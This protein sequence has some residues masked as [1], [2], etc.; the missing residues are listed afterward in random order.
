MFEEAASYQLENQEDSIRYEYQIIDM[1]NFK[2]RSEYGGQHLLQAFC[3]Q[4]YSFRI[5]RRKI[6]PKHKNPDSSNFQYQTIIKLVLGN[7]DLTKTICE[8]WS[9][10]HGGRNFLDIIG[11]D[12]DDYSFLDPFTL[13]FE[14]NDK[15]NENLK[16]MFGFTINLSSVMFSNF[17]RQHLKHPMMHLILTTYLIESEKKFL[18]EKYSCNIINFFRG[19]KVASIMANQI[20]SD[21]I[22]QLYIFSEDFTDSWIVKTK[23]TIDNLTEY[24]LPEFDSDYEMNGTFFYSS[25]SNSISSPELI[26]AG[27]GFPF[28]LYIRC[29]KIQNEEIFSVTVSLDYVESASNKFYKL[30]SINELLKRS[31]KTINERLLHICTEGVNFS[32]DILDYWQTSDDR[33]RVFL[34]WIPNKAGNRILFN[35]KI[36]YQEIIDLCKNYQ[37]SFNYPLYEKPSTKIEDNGPI[38]ITLSVHFQSLRWQ[39]FQEYHQIRLLLHNNGKRN[40]MLEKNKAEIALI[41]N[42][43]KKYYDFFKD[44]EILRCP[45]DEFIADEFLYSIKDFYCTSYNR[46]INVNEITI[47][48]NITIA[49]ETDR[50]RIAEK[51]KIYV[52]NSMNLFP[53]PFP[54]IVLYYTTF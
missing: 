52:T 14:W 22:S 43:T 4:E 26:A 16:F 19:S 47:I 28:I 35:V 53:P 15:T 7:D 13:Q 5:N 6:P 38:T 3:G 50:K 20:K 25:I 17:Q 9:D 18:Y 48:P 34:L 44:G 8:Q 31:K 37:S 41:R 12:D 1:N 51:M 11:L 36:N 40:G 32:D 45:I 33:S 21:S 42:E 39:I 54:I 29:I 30:I 49:T 46:R 23:N 24:R 10:R 27:E 2:I